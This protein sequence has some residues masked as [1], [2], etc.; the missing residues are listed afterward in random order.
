[1][2]QLS[3]MDESTYDIILWTA[4]IFGMQNIQSCERGNRQHK[5]SKEIELTFEQNKH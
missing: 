3:E 2:E 5:L 1:M 4:R